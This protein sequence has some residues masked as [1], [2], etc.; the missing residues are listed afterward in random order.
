M[1]LR[2][3]F[4]LPRPLCPAP[5]LDLCISMRLPGVGFQHLGWVV[6]AAQKPQED[7]A[8]LYPH[9]LTWCLT[10]WPSALWQ[11]LAPGFSELCHPS[12]RG[13]GP[14]GPLETSVGPRR[15]VVMEGQ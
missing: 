11:G 14:A 9:P 15:Q 12:W 8:G 1:A 6:W 4:V 10:Q 2:N 5:F 3:D 7:T 13:K